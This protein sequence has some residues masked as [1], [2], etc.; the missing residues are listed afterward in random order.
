MKPESQVA[1]SAVD[2]HESQ[3]A[4]SA[5]DKHESQVARSAVDKNESLKT[6]RLSLRDQLAKQR[7]VIAQQLTPTKPPPLHGRSTF[8]RSLTMRLLIQNPAPVLR[9]TLGL[10]NWVLG[11]RAKGPIRAGLQLLNLLRL[12]RLH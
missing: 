1:R 6:R 11:A 2:K 3:V 8:P 4:R 7:A 10:A 9:I 12:S 5:V